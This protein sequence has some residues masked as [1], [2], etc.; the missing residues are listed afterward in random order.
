[1]VV[2]GE[3]TAEADYCL[4]PSPKTRLQVETNNNTCPTCQKMLIEEPE[5]K[6][7]PK[8][9]AIPALEGTED[10]NKDKNKGK[11]ESEDIRG[12]L[13]GLASLGSTKDR[14]DRNNDVRLKPPTYKGDSDPTHFF[15]KIGQFPRASKCVKR[16]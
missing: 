3:T 6:I 11:D 14:K 13:K 10:E 5:P 2:E 16:N 15:C 4:C 1:M 9:E 8:Y 7:E 12:L